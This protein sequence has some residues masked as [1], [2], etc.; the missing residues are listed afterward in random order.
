MPVTPL[1]PYPVAQQVMDRARAFVN[2]A[3]QA[4]RGRILTNENPF[5]VQFLNSALEEL[6]Q[7]LRNRGVITLT[8]DNVIL[9]PITPPPTFGPGQQ[10]RIAFQ[11]FYNGTTWVATPALPQECI[12]VLEVWER[13]TGA[14][15]AFQPMTQQR[16]LQDRSQSPWLQSW[17]YR[18]DSIILIGSTVTEGLRIRFQAQLAPIAAASATNPLSNVTINI[19]A[20]VNALAKL[21]AYNYAL[22]LGAPAAETMA[23][24]AEKYVRLITNSY[25]RQN[26]RVPYRRQI[27]GDRNNNS[28]TRL[29]F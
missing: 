27:F 11:G 19:L 9:T 25:T 12:S 1:A 10:Q 17:E 23:Q 5:T 28:R 16:P 2:D 21:V 8:Y 4:G 15:T 18:Q 24:D 3:F 6:Q 7:R 13:Q 22:A 14:G 29:P 20:S 26:Q